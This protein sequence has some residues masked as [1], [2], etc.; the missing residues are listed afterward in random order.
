MSQGDDTILR[1]GDCLA[2][3]Y[4]IL[5]EIGRGGF[6]V[7][8]RAV[9][10]GV[11]RS[12]A[13]KTLRRQQTY[14]PG[15]DFVEAF[16][17]EALHTSHLKHPNTITLFDFGE[18][19]DGL[20]YLVTE[21]LEGE[22]LYER[23]WRDRTMRPET[24]VHVARQIAK[25]LAEAHNNGIIHGDLKPANIFLCNLY[26]E[27]DFVKV[28][29][30]G[31]AKIIG[32]VDPAGM[33]TPEY[34]SPEQFS[35]QPLLA[36]S[37]VYSLGL[38]VF[39]MAM[40]RRPF[41]DEDTGKLARKH[42]LEPMPPMSS[43]LESSPLG[44]LIRKAT[45]KEPSNR[46]EDGWA[47][48]EALENTSR[49]TSG[50]T[51]ARPA[52][53][54]AAAAPPPAVSLMRPTRSDTPTMTSVPAMASSGVD[55]LSGPSN[56]DLG[57]DGPASSGGAPL[58]RLSGD[59]RPASSRLL[60]GTRLPLIGR[61]S[62]EAWLLDRVA[63]VMDTRTPA[64]VILG[65]AA[66]VGKTRLALWL[67]EEAPINDRALRGSGAQRD[68]SPFVLE[69]L[70]TAFARACGMAGQDFGAK[71][72]RRIKQRLGEVL[73]GDLPERMVEAVDSL[74]GPFGVDETHIDLA[75]VGDM[76]L[77]VAS[78]LPLVLH[79]DNVQS[80]D[81]TTLDFLDHL[82]ERLPK[83]KCQLFLLCTVRREALPAVPVIAR[84]LV[85]MVRNKIA[86]PRTLDALGEE[87]AASLALRVLLREIGAQG[88][89]GEPD[90]ALI[91][92]L[93]RRSHGNPLYI[94]ELIR[95]L[96][97]SEFVTID[98]DT[99]VASLKDAVQLERMIPPKI[100]GLLRLRVAQLAHRHAQGQEL[101]H[102]LLRCAL[103]GPTIPVELISIFLS[104]EATTLGD[105]VA[106]SARSQLNSL[107]NTLSQEDI[108]APSHRKT[109]AGLE[110]ELTF[111]QPLIHQILEERV[112]RLS[113]ARALH[114]VAAESKRSY[115]AEGGLLDKAADQ[116]ALHYTLADARHEAVGFF[117]DAAVSSARSGNL[118]E[119]VQWLDQ[120]RTAADGPDCALVRL[121]TLLDLCVF[122]RSIGGLADLEAVKV[123]SDR[124]VEE[125]ASD[126]A[127]ADL[128][129]LG[130]QL[131]RVRG[132]VD[133]A[134]T[135]FK[136]A[137]QAYS[138]LPRS[139]SLTAEQRLYDLRLLHLDLHHL[140]PKIG[141]GMACLG[142]AWAAC[143][144]ARFETAQSIIAT[145]IGAFDAAGFIWGRATS[146]HVAADLYLEHGYLEDAGQ[147]LTEAR[148]LFERTT[149][150]LGVAEVAISQ[151]ELALLRGDLSDADAELR[152]RAKQVSRAGTGPWM[153][154]VA[155][156]QGRFEA[157][158]GNVE[159][160]YEHFRR[161]LEMTQNQCDWTDMIT[162]LI[163]F[164]H[165]LLQ[166]GDP[167]NAMRATHKAAALL[168]GDPNLRHIPRLELLLSAIHAHA[169]H[170]AEARR[171]S[172]AAI[173]AA[174]LGGDRLALAAAHGTIALLGTRG[175]RDTT[176]DAA[177]GHLKAARRV[178]SSMGMGLAVICRAEEVLSDDLSHRGDI[179]HGLR[180]L[181]DAMH[182]W[183]RLG[184][185]GEAYR[186][187][188]RIRHNP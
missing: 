166:V 68:G 144:R 37:D 177:L 135:G 44:F 105:P 47:M 58:E 13:I 6:G 5:E 181:E 83:E 7:V 14:I 57:F 71:V 61:G 154:K 147:L 129:F 59:P 173:E 12:V 32:D 142:L 87:G 52:P 141:V 145:A 172:L 131:A 125:L 24:V 123:L 33:G 60:R 149:P 102:L 132:D 64:I 39:E 153:A 4:V 124:L 151:V 70:R 79:L 30:F 75:L 16:H 9:Q 17:K 163:E 78:R 66:G 2:G 41:D 133:T 53:T 116:I 38:I 136:A 185:V 72:A 36:A 152:T 103:L 22:T 45:S 101:E 55:L 50:A 119:T 155:R 159:A 46:Y 150:A 94:L 168:R 178:A 93:V 104:A 146:L 10:Q 111:T 164:A 122:R 128:L 74:Y 8:Y 118:L 49:R 15:F 54:P 40:G 113:E 76:F 162:L 62:E 130:A 19:D 99:R 167:Q 35:G 88:L 20:L 182:G 108:L 63:T 51:I 139:E 107:L 84:R 92:G 179:P 110:T 138:A 85:G 23:M 91:E 158:R 120:A 184:N 176:L 127:Q 115:L 169:H 27:R 31:I 148:R 65:G 161:A 117:R 1:P 100:G 160:A 143:E 98:A 180:L 134:T 106:A 89:T 21:F 95:H 34:M 121:E 43:A 96:M 26:G 77:G 56:V 171:L 157:S 109:V 187:E 80:A 82:T 156:L 165:F 97:D 81:P 67:V 186:L 69:G 114:K 140:P 3:R 48:Y 126:G 18:T 25:S 137:V 175:S 29:D 174:D 188:Q 183:T 11:N 112:L 42:L 73:G 86:I 90:A 28:L 170:H